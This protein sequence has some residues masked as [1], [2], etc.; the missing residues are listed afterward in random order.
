MKK[1]LTTNQI[2]SIRITI[3]IIRNIDAVFK[4]QARHFWYKCL[5]KISEKFENKSKEHFLKS[6][7]TH[8]I[9]TFHTS[10]NDSNLKMKIGKV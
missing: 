5:F 7:D 4:I 2:N 9:C 3:V 6:N 10:E 8:S 1:I